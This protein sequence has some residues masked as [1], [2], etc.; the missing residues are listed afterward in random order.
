MRKFRIKD[1]LRQGVVPS[2]TLFTII[3]DAV[4]NESEKKKK[5]HCF[6]RIFKACCIGLFVGGKPGMG[7]GRKCQ[8]RSYFLRPFESCFDVII[9]GFFTVLRNFT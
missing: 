1:G 2:S 8:K 6:Y 7:D 4:I 3:R 5:P 9:G